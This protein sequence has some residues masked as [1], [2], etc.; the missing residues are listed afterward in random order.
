VATARHW[1]W[2]WP[3]RTQALAA[4]L[5]ALCASCSAAWGA[6]GGCL[7]AQVLQERDLLQKRPFVSCTV[8]AARCTS[9]VAR[10]GERAAR[11]TSARRDRGAGAAAGKGRLGAGPFRSARTARGTE[12]RPRSSAARRTC[13][14]QL[15]LRAASGRG[16]ACVAP[17]HAETGASMRARAGPSGAGGLGCE[18]RLLP[19]VQHSPAFHRAPASK[20]ASARAINRR[21]R[22]GGRRGVL[23]HPSPLPCVRAENFGRL[24]K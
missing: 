12:W 16:G 2:R 24:G 23:W 3:Q 22:D 19:P 8:H 9:C 10:C 14:P 17:P 5:P 6:D 15:Q 13:R 4:A 20:R 21:C 11:C 7:E 18:I 1:D